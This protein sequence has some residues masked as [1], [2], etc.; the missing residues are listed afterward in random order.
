MWGHRGSRGFGVGVQSQLCSRPPSCYMYLYVNTTAL[1]LEQNLTR[2]QELRERVRNGTGETGAPRHPWHLTILEA[3]LP[4]TPKSP[5]PHALGS[6][7]APQKL[8]QRSPC[9]FLRRKFFLFR[10]SALMTLIALRNLALG[11]PAP[12]R[13]AQEVA[14]ASWRGE[15]EE[16]HSHPGSS[17]PSPPHPSSPKSFPHSH[18]PRAHCCL[19]L[20]FPHTFSPSLLP[21]PLS[22]TP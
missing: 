14:F 16:P 1:E 6:T 19:V 13:L 10:R 11:R 12:E 3:L 5:S 17:I 8:H 7:G 4:G 18:C 9:R 20:H 21:H 22:L 2:L 15:E